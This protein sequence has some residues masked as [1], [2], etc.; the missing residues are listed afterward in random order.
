ML[1]ACERFSAGT[2]VSIRSR[3]SLEPPVEDSGAGVSATAAAVGM[4]VGGAVCARN[5][6]IHPRSVGVGARVP[7]ACLQESR[8]LVTNTVWSS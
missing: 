2:P 7:M 1:S 4:S 8:R 3:A 6:E 5:V